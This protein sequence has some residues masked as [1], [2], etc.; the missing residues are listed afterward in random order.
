MADDFK[1]HIDHHARL[2]PPAELV[3]A[4]AAHVRG[5]LDDAGLRAAE[6]AAIT[7]ALRM[8]RR[9]G[10][11]AVSDGQL[12]RRNPLS[13]VYDGV[14]GFGAEI[15]AGGALAELLGPSLVPEWRGL[16][17]QPVA[18]GRLTEHEAGFLLSSAVDRPLMLSLPSPGYVGAL[19]AGDRGP[20]TAAAL[21]RI[22]RDEVAA[23][24]ADGVRHV[25]LHNPVYA[26]LLTVEGRNR[27]TAAGIDSDSLIGSMLDADA[28]AIADLNTPEEFRVSLD[29]TTA[30]AAP[31]GRGYDGAALAVFLDRQPFDRLCVEFPRAEQ[32]R[33]PIERVPAGCVVALGVVDVGTAEPEPVEELVERVDKAA[34]VLDVDDIAISTNGGFAAGGAQ[35]T[36]QQQR[37][38]LQLVEM[39][40]RYFWG[41]EL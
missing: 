37:A 6:D 23:L 25:L 38:K 13:V 11:S 19:C 10:L 18:R 29:L 7:D 16:E 4:R 14:R 5:R 9:V 26:F 15:G 28:A 21:A 34:T 27:A 17:E 39:T 36:G 3:G 22:I 41:N 35:L 1:Y 12:R 40:A 31:A 32:D 20:G 24:A 30:G 8:Q 33:F 2:V